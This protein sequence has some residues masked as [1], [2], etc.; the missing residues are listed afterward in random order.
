MKILVISNLYPPNQLGGYEIGCRNVVNGLRSRGH[1]VHVLTSPSHFKQT[2]AEESVF[3][4]L[5][6]RA[7]QFRGSETSLTQIEAKVSNYTNTSVT[8][9]HIK[10][11]G[12]DCVYLFNL[13]GLGG[14]G[15][16]DALNTLKYTWVMHLMDQLPHMLQHGV[17]PAILELFN[18]NHG[19][20]YRTGKLISMSSHLMR[21]IKKNCGFR[22][23]MD[24]DLI[25]GWAD[26][27]GPVQERNYLRNGH[28]Q[29]VT[30]GAIHAHKGIDVIIQ[31]VA[32][33]KQ[34]MISNFTVSIYGNGKQAFYIDLCKQLQVQDHVLFKAMQ[35]QAELIEIYRSS[36][37]FLFPTWE[38]EP[39]GFAPIEAAAVGCVPIIT[40][41]C[42]AAERL[43]RNV[44]CMKIRR[45]SA[46]LRDAMK[47]VCSGLTPLAAIGKNA[48][49]I[50]RQDLS[51]SN[52]L[53]RIES[54]LA[55][56]VYKAKPPNTPDWL[57]NNLCY[58]KHNLAVRLSH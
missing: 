40:H 34:E 16:I 2:N 49:T 43:I 44:N 4:N 51:F 20:A 8:L 33:L 41:N 28:A 22:Y 52:C 23:A 55:T 31:A 32:L 25:P 3:R 37:A 47:S 1:E 13:Y 15:I 5:Q 58:L 29:F 10:E 30:A 7:F 54:I 21:E 11:F 17:H 39:F 50:A 53:G 19:N 56:A 46:S 24:A 9:A 42:G 18:A 57:L 35:T 27:D 48:Q 14:L 26:A 45:T 38:R 12:P 6:L 36:D